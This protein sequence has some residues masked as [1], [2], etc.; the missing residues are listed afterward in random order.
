MTGVCGAHHVLRVKH[1]LGQLG[2]SQG[3][4]LLRSTRSER[5]E[6]CH[7]EVQ[8]RK[9]DEVHSDLP[10]VTVQLP[11]ETQASC[12]TTHCSTHQMV[13]VPISGSRELQGTEANV[14]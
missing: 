12:H 9:R 7:E 3:A 8:A 1:L 13:E 4:V 14:V 6:A 11:W 5:S 2:H 10:E